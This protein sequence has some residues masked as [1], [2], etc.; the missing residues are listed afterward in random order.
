MILQLG[1]CAKIQLL[2]SGQPSL[3][4][5]SRSEINEKLLLLFILYSNCLAECFK[6]N[7]AFSGAV[8]VLLSEDF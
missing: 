1:N 6:N 2:T 4:S 8:L 3:G 5:T 7:Y